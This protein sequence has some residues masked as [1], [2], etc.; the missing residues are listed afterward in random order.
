MEELKKAAQRAT[1]A[2]WAEQSSYPCRVVSDTRTRTH[3]GDTRK[4]AFTLPEWGCHASSNDAHAN[5]IR[6]ATPTAV[7]ELIK[8]VEMLEKEKQHWH[9]IAKAAVLVDNDE[10]SG[11]EVV[12]L[13]IDTIIKLEAR[14]KSAEDK[15]EVDSVG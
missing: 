3:G 11:H 12:N 1:R 4:Q 9:N 14:A 13:L 2:S 7:L 8:K 5:F 15:V 6:L 10:G